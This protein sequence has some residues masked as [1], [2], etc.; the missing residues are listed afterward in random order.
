VD[1]AIE[2]LRE[3]FKPGRMKFLVVR[4]GI[5]SEVAG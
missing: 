2:A 1:K 3:Q 5:E 4:R